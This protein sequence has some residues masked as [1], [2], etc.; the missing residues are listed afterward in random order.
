MQNQ[1]NPLVR[2]LIA[3]AILASASAAHAISVGANVGATVDGVTQAVVDTGL[4]G[5]VQAKLAAD[6]R[7]KGSDIAVTSENN[8]VILTGKAPSADARAAAEAVAK[9][10][11]NADVRVVNRIEAPGVL[12]AIGG[13]VK[14]AADTTGEVITDS[15]ISTKIKSQLLADTATKGTAIKVTTKDN[16]VFLKGTVAT[17]AE[18][19]QAIALAKQTKGVARVNA[20]KLKVSTRVKANADVNAQ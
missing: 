10:A 3:A 17:K 2:T 11:V 15:W 20:S 16:V 4:T 14:V 19:N 8:V 12:S 5:S 13:D 18:R 6:T 1:N 9:S 7:L